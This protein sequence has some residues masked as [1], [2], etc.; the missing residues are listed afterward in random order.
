MTTGRPAGRGRG[1]RTA[2]RALLRTPLLVDGRDADDD[3]RLV[4]R[5]RAELTRL[6]AEGLGYRLVVE[7]GVVRLVKTG[8]GGADGARPCCAATGRRSRPAATPS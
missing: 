3:L 7:P 1:A 5:H 2:A 6:F 8:L 4:R